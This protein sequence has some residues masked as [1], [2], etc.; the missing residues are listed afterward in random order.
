VIQ[1]SDLHL[2]PES[3]ST[4]FAVL[5][6]ICE[7]AVANGEKTVAF[8]GDWWHVR[9]SVP[10]ELLNAVDAELERWLASGIEEVI[11]LPGNHDQVDVGG[12]NA[13]QV[14]AR[15]GV[16]VHSSPA[17][18]AHGLWLPYRR[19]PAVLGELAMSS[20]AKRCFVHH[21]LIGAQM[22]TGV[23]A[24]AADGIAPV[25]FQNFQTAFFGH[26]HR[27]QQ[28]G[29]CVYVGSPWQTKMD[30]AGQP[31][32][33][34]QLNEET[35]EW[36]HVP[37]S[38]GSQFIRAANRTEAF[39]ARPGDTVRLPSDTPQELIQE[40]LGSGVEVRVDPPPFVPTQ[41][42]LGLDKNTSM[43]AYAAK[44]VEAQ[45]GDLDREVLMQ[46]FDE[47]SDG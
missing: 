28:I 36:R 19:D 40:L 10:V 26:W 27:H 22:N 43:R 35:G 4:C 47:V 11:L 7:F 39:R 13:L 5:D 34:I 38:V 3:A 8:L 2:K 29:N 17:E 9:Y 1:F 33:L 37:F 18:D 14:L 21:G 32:G 44:Y 45:H 6:A 30:E 25:A 41:S 31:K 16:V 42:R 23:T 24:G 20:K 46:I 15:P 12:Q